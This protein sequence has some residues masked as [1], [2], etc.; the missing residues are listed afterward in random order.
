MG[1]NTMKPPSKWDWRKHMKIKERQQ[2]E[3][4]DHLRAETRELLAGISE[5][6]NAVR[7]RVVNRLAARAKKAEG[8]N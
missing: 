3:E 2:I 8:S 4:L 1:E 7:G 5:R 6:Y